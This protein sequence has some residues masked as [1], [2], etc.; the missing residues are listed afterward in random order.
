MHQNLR[1]HTIVSEPFAENSYIV[2]LPDGTDVFVVDPGFD[3][4]SILQYLE[5]QGLTPRAIVNTHGHVDHIAGN[6]AL[7]R[8]FPDAPIIIGV[9]DVPM[10]TDAFEN[11]SA[12]FGL[13]VTSPP[14]DRTVR[15]GE[16]LEL[17]GIEWEVFEIPGHS[18]G[19]VVFVWRGQPNVV[20]GGDVLF[21]GSV[22]R[23]DLPG[24]SFEL[25]RCGIEGK[26]WPLPDDTIV[27]P[28]HG[29]VTTIGNEKRSNPFVGE[30]VEYPM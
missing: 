27:Y 15:E 5:E 4:Q 13:P 12:Q 25:L 6:R 28:G 10:L 11:M 1:L 22:G 30:Q 24:G 18:P 17:A 14:A 29:P 20:L 8:A 23:T 3:P 26:L 16:R 9:G 7:K 2:G 19:H 21:R